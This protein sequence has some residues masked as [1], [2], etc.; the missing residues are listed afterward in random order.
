M[1]NPSIGR[2]AGPLGQEAIFQTDDKAAASV[3]SAAARQ[4]E[5]KESLQAIQSS[6]TPAGAAK[7]ADKNLKD[8]KV[9]SAKEVE[10][11]ELKESAFKPAEAIGDKAADD[12]CRDN[13]D[14]P[15]FTKPAL[16]NLFDLLTKCDTPE[17]IVKLVVTNYPDP[18]TAIKAFEFLK[19]GLGAWFQKAQETKNKALETHIVQ[20]L[21][22]VDTAMKLYKTTNELEIARDEKLLRTAEAYQ[23]TGLVGSAKTLDAG[24]KDALHNAPDK[25]EH[26]KKLVADAILAGKE[27]GYSYPALRMITQFY[28]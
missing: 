22:M 4:A 10:K 12:F 8:L 26:F 25:I 20:R 11:E 1:V 27:K 23:K 28:Y 7:L 5:T 17:S 13:S 9:K 21:A 24:F 3:E 18:L 2:P 15:A 14:D 6:L 19:T 16:K